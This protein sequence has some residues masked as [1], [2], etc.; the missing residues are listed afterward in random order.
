MTTHETWHCDRFYWTVLVAPGFRRPGEL[1][2]G[3]RPLLEDETPLEIEHLHAVC[4]PR[5]DGTLAVCAIDLAHLNQLMP[6]TLSLTPNS[7]P[8]FLDGGLR[9]EDFN[10][11]VGRFE[12]HPLRLARLRAHGLRALVFLLCGLLVAIGLQRRAWHWRAQASAIHA[13]AERVA[14]GLAVASDFRDIEAEARRLRSTREMLANTS[15]QFDAA[16]A[17]GAV[18]DSWPANTPSK[19]HSISVNSTGVT[20]SVSFDGDASN[21]LEAFTPAPGWTLDE[22]RLNTAEQTTRLTLHLRPSGS[23]SVS[24]P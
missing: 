5:N 11:L 2:V 23:K 12:P 17:L 4:V 19:P 16:V 3:L 6:E 20:L 9:A 1:P 8:S 13:S 21:F 10:L 15:P 18:L 24:K 7:L 14:A 22:P